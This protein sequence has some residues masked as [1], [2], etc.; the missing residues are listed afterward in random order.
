MADGYLEVVDVPDLPA[1]LCAIAIG[2]VPVIGHLYKKY[3]LKSTKVRS[4]EFSFEDGE[5]LQLDGEDV[6][7]K[8]G[9][10]VAIEFASQVQMLRLGD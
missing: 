9:N 8:L 4:L 3:F 5:F 2:T 10:T 6:S 1:F 7:G